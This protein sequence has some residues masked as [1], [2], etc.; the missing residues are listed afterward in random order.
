MGAY[1]R[2]GSLNDDVNLFSQD[3][4]YSIPLLSLIGRG[5]LNLNLMLTYNSK[6]WIKSGSTIYLDGEQGWPA[7][8]W[9][10]G[11]GRIDGVYSGPD[12]YNHYYY[13]APDGSV[14]DLRYTSSSSLY[15]SIDSTYLDFNDSTGILRLRDG[16][17]ITFALQGSSGGYVLPTQIKDRNGNYITIN[18]SGT[19]QQI[20]SIVDT[21][22]R[23]TNFS[24]NG[25]G[26]LASISKS[27]FGNASRTWSFSYSSLALS[28]SFATSLT[29]NAPTSV[30]VLSSITFPNS[31]LQTFSYNGYGQLTEADIKSSSSTAR[32]K[33][34]V[35]WNS[36]PGGGWTDSPTPATIGNNDGSTTNTWSLSFGTYATTVT[37]PASVATTTTFINSGSWDDGLPSQTQ[38]GSTALMTTANTWGNDGNSINQRITRI[39]T[40]LNDIN[41]QSK[42]ETDYTSYGN[43]S[44]IRE[45]DFGSGS[46]G[47]QLRKT[48]YTY[49]T[50]SNYASR[51]ILGLPA[52]IIVYNGSGTAKSRMTFTYDSASLSSATGTSN[53]DDTNY[54]TG[55]TYRGL[56]TSVTG[57]ADA[58][59]PSGSVTHSATYDMLGNVLTSTA[60]CCIQFQYNF[61]ST[62]NYSQPD[63]VVR[64]SGTTLTTSATYDSYTGLVAISTDENNQTTSYSYD[65]MDRETSLTR[66]DSTVI[67]TSYDDSSASPALT[68]TKPITSAL[69]VKNMTIFDG[70][71]RAI[72]QSILDA[73]NSVYSKTDIQ[74][75]GLGRV[76]QTSLPYTGTSATYWTQSQFDALGRTAKVIPADGSSSSNN[77]SFSYSGNAMTTTDESGKQHKSVT[78]ALGRQIETDEPDPS[79]SNSLTLTTTYTYDPMNNLTQISQGSQTRTYVFDGLRRK[80]SETTPEA[81][82]ISYQYNSYGKMTQKTD[83][84]GVVTTITYDST[85]NR[86]TQVS[87]NVSGT[88]AAS[89]PTVNYT[90]GTS[91]SSYNNGRLTQMTDGLGTESFT[92][93]QLGRNT[94]V[95]KTVYN[96]A[97]TT[98][99]TFNLAGQV[100]TMTYPSGRVIKNNYDSI[101]RATSVQNNS[102]SAN[103]ASSITYNTANE[104]TGFSYGNGIT[105]SFGYSAQRLQLTSIGYSQGSSSLFSLS[106]SYTQNGGN[107]GAITSITDNVVA[108]RTENFTYDSLQRL[109]S[110]SITGTSGGGGGS[111]PAW[112]LSWTYDRYG[113]RTAQ[114]VT[115]GSAPSVSPT[116]SSSTNQITSMGGSSFTYDSS[117]NLTQDDQYQYIYDGENHQVT[118]KNLSGTTVATYAY[119]GNGRRIVK[120]WG[121]SR[122]VS[123]FAGSN[124]IS[125]FDD[126]ASNTYSSGTTPGGAVTDSSAVLLYYHSDHQSVRLTTD[127]S[128]N[129]ANKQGTF[130]FG[131]TWYSGGTADPSVELKFTT[132]LQDNE[133]ANAKLH[134]AQS[135][136]NSVRIARFQTPDPVRGN[137]GNPQRLN[138]YSYVLNDPVNLTDPSGL[139]TRCDSDSTGVGVLP[140]C[141]MLVWGGDPSGFGCTLDG[142]LISCGSMNRED[143]VACPTTNC[144]KINRDGLL[145]R[146]EA[147]EE[148]SY[149]TCVYSGE[150]RSAN[151][152]GIAAVHCAN[153]QSIATGRELSGNVYRSPNGQYSFTRAVEGGTRD[154]SFDPSAIPNATIY[155]GNYHTHGTASDYNGRYEQFSPALCQGFFALGTC[156]VENALSPANQGRPNYL[157][158]PEGRVL[159]LIPS[160]V[161]SMYPVGCVLVGSPVPPG[162]YRSVNPVPVC[163]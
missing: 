104:V 67:S 68:V 90:Y 134:Y 22:G 52:S 62:T 95:Q 29:V 57:Y 110:A 142:I 56:V 145:M 32:G 157:G 132:Y 10:L 41:Q 156:D 44:E 85:L 160:L 60:D 86:L 18:Y 88:S 63:S 24:Y 58:A 45:Y 39:I 135:R 149:Y 113:N 148:G 108:G 163:H 54:G 151:S 20:S 71:G 8:G 136:E 80:T 6:V 74:Y 11:F 103:Y 154:S 9:R 125:E 34:L 21:V 59:T 116:I 49:V 83:A 122:T 5:G 27:G 94:Q 1:A 15:E 119:D 48:D 12:S 13:I 120:V 37:D 99:W 114:A 124:L 4:S 69:S 38:V 3:V 91:T 93:D 23:T 73:S 158:T 118:L 128:G 96:V 79:N 51:H 161:E 78:D 36:A 46:P 111:Y 133:A 92:Y 17:Q 82:T 106:Y 42:V 123:L 76:S 26:T 121:A 141:N 75:D 7:P 101:G 70:L 25:D 139:D 14:H 130:P 147:T 162:P 33:F 64:G 72:R 98:S 81:G 150:W 137:V 131:E 138:R 53:H 115:T 19:G 109:T 100:V 47:S 144:T 87:Y 31:T 129:Y 30:K 28:Y 77:I 105:A 43:S 127:N 65:V 61:S 107:D 2:A 66:P 143:A 155:Q 140:T 153:E 97:Y 40:T 50:D 112:G 117:G 35:S 146:Y 84:R 55:F 152:A 126:A 159:I 89:T 16:T 102:T